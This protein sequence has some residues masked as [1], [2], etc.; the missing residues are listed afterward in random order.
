[1]NDVVV[2]ISEAVN[3]E[4]WKTATGLW[5]RAEDVVEA[6]TNGVNF[7]NI[8]KWQ[9][10]DSRSNMVKKVMPSGRLGG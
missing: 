6:N 9:S 1:M 8:L 5:S 3:K 7:Y 10:G 4:Q 2:E